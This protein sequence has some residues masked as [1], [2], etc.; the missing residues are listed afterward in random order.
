MVRGHEPYK[1][2]L[3]AWSFVPEGNVCYYSV[4]YLVPVVDFLFG[5]YNLC[6]LE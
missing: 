3:P 4:K 1:F 6:K 2:K 5:L